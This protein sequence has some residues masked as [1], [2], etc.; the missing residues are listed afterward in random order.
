MSLTSHPTGPPLRLTSALIGLVGLGVAGCSSGCDAQG[1]GA[2]TCSPACPEGFLC[3]SSRGCQAQ[4]LPTKSVPAQGWPGRGAQ[5]APSGELVYI[6][7]AD[8]DT[9]EL[10][11]GPLTPSLGAPPSLGVLAEGAVTD[12]RALDIAS[13]SGALAVAWRDDSG[14]YQ[15][16]TKSQGSQSP[17]GVERIAFVG[18]GASYS[19]SADFDLVLDDQAQP[20]LAFRDPRTPRPLLRPT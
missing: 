9:R 15:L 17:W 7:L 20:L 6:A 13:R 16:A 2:S 3:S 4:S 12:G 19:A 14:T 18:P 11:V 5:L 8:P 10:L 1:Q